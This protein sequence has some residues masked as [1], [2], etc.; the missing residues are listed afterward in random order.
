MNPIIWLC[1]FVVYKVHLIA[2]D[3]V[4][5]N[6]LTLLQADANHYTPIYPVLSCIDWDNI[7]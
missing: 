6:L 2:S 4:K 7:L 5:P 1:N 3:G